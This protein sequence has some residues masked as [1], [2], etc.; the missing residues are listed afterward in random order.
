MK[1]ISTFIFIYLCTIVSAC[2]S[3]ESVKHINGKKAGIP[4][5]LPKTVFNIELERIETGKKNEI[6]LQMNAT[7]ERVPDES[8]IYLMSPVSGWGFVDSN[9]HIVL[10]NGLLDSV[11][12]IDDGQAGSVLNNIVSTLVNVAKTAALFDG[13]SD[14]ESPFLET[15][16]Y[17]KNTEIQALLS[18]I[19]SDSVKFTFEP[20][21]KTNTQINLPGTGGLLYVKLGEA[22]RIFEPG[23]AI[24][25]VSTPVIKWPE[26]KSK[27]NV[28]YQC[29]KPE[30]YRE[31]KGNKEV[32]EQGNK[33]DLLQRYVKQILEKFKPYD[34]SENQTNENMDQQKNTETDENSEKTDEE[35]PFKNGIYAR[36]LK[37][38]NFA[39]AIYVDMPKLTALRAEHMISDLTV[40]QNDLLGLMHEKVQQ[41]SK[42]CD[43]STTPQDSNKPSQT[44]QKELESQIEKLSLL[45]LAGD[46]GL[47]GEKISVRRAELQK[48]L[49][50]L[51][52]AA[53][54]KKKQCKD[55]KDNLDENLLNMRETCI[56]IAK[57]LESIDTLRNFSPAKNYLVGSHQE[58]LLI[59]DEKPVRIPVSRAGIGTTANNLIFD[60]GILV[61]YYQTRPAE[62]KVL[63]DSLVTATS[64][65]YDG[66]VEVLRT[67]ITV[68]GIETDKAEAA[69]LL[70][71]QQ[72]KLRRKQDQL[73]GTRAEIEKVLLDARLDDVKANPKAYMC[74]LD[75]SCGDAGETTAEEENLDSSDSESEEAG[76]NE[77]LADET[78]SGEN[79]SV[80]GSEGQTETG[81]TLVN[82]LSEPGSESADDINQE[83]TSLATEVSLLETDLKSRLDETRTSIQS[84][85]SELKNLQAVISS[86]AVSS[87]GP[88]DE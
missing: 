53:S 85:L 45:T 46:G 87:P 51:K 72:I 24:N 48:K 31:V 52:A 30:L 29:T 2:S 38:Y 76:Q 15:A 71:D 27:D 62:A 32:Q 22:S 57:R 60:K 12:T 10:E 74:L 36:T 59:V 61:D 17:P 3:L 73:D 21:S 7:A 42:N 86:P 78:E 80:E 28:I 83:L 13:Q 81:E 5:S 6:G 40:R 19:E 58:S 37:N 34:S 67:P 44:L 1:R 88:T 49:D 41:Q 25:P 82:N 55:A 64:A 75:D 43:V 79:E 14:D 4:Y 68:L 23:T 66:V 50:A 65:L 8:Q 18:R 69:E 47:G 9:H 70:T 16:N 35:K 39:G 33:N 11:N 63:T 26:F 54:K 84:I 77:T 56:G 20:A